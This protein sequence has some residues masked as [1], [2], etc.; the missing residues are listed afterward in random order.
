MRNSCLV[1]AT[2][3]ALV[4]CHKVTDYNVIKKSPVTTSPSPAAQPGEIVPQIAYTYTFAFKLPERRIAEVQARHIALCDRLGSRCHLVSMDQAHG[5]GRADADLELAVAADV[6]RSFGDSLLAAV[7]SGDGETTERTIQGE[8]LSKQIVDV[9][10]RLRGRQAL[11]DRL[12]QVVQTHK[13]SVADLVAAEKSLA[14]VQE[15]IDTARSELTEARGRVAM[16]LVRI[17]YE[18]KAGLGSFA[19]PIGDGLAH[20]GSIAGMSVAA[21]LS[22]LAALLPWLVPIA[23]IAF[24]VRWWKLRRQTN[25]E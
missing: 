1:I 18:K 17:S 12:L 15:E 24:G 19:T 3:L 2:A 10:A 16:S 13:G 9:E 23:L 7:A 8:D 14:D 5:A 21:L 25:D 20:M 4:G 6:A 11:A 22:L